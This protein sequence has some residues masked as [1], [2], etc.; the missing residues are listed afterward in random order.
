MITV[1]VDEGKRKMGVEKSNEYL[2]R[3]GKRETRKWRAKE[4]GR[5]S[6]VQKAKGGF[7]SLLLTE[8]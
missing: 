8:P 4:E 7:D 5:N 3:K 2:R 6:C 1:I